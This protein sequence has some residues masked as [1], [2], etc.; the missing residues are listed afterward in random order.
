M[1][2]E[3][4]AILIT[5]NMR[6][7]ELISLIDKIS[8]SDSSVLLIGET[9]VGK[10]VFADYVHRTSLRKHKPFVK[11]GLSAL[12]SELLESE[13]FGHEK[14]SFTSAHSEKQGLFEI[15]NGGSIFLDDIDDVPIAIQTKLLRVLESGELMRVGGTK[16]IPVDVRLITATKIDLKLLIK[17]DKF[18]SDLYYRINVVPLTIPPL[19]ER[20]DD[21]PLLFKHFLAHYAGEK[22]LSLSDKASKALSFY[23]WPGNVRELRN[24]AQRLALFGESEIKL[25]ELPVEFQQTDGLDVLLKACDNCFIENSMSFDQIVDCLQI[26]ILKQALQEH[27][28]NQSQAARA[29]KMSLSTFRDKLKKYNILNPDLPVIYAEIRR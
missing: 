2:P 14:G 18:R 23:N 25:S 10:E 19:R 21:I 5:Q 17:M 28:R 1:N 13:L 20:K 22:Q 7:L 26:N 6:M 29:L 8:H 24:V 16:F 15:A 9:G 3:K 12:P 11:V 27:G 4:L